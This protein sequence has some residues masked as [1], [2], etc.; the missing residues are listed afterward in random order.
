MTPDRLAEIEAR[1]A[2]AIADDLPYMLQIRK[3]ECDAA[4]AW[5]HAHADRGALLAEVRRLRAAIEHANEALSDPNRHTVISAGL[6]HSIIAEALE[7]SRG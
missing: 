6:A 2:K 5:A 7:V 1:H 3:N 4:W